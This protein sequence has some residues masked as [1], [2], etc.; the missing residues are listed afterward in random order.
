VTVSAF[1]VAG[2]RL[3]T[4]CQPRSRGYRDYLIIHHAAST[5]LLGTLDLMQ[6]G[7]RTVSSSW[8]L[9]T[10]GRFW[11]VV[12]ETMRP[13]TSASWLDD[14]A[15]TVETI[16]TSGDPNW[17]IAEDQRIALAYLAVRLYREGHLKSLTRTHI[18]GHYEVIRIAGDGY[19]TACPGPSMYL[20]HIAELARAIHAGLP[21]TGAFTPT[22]GRKHMYSIVPDAKSTTLFVVSQVTGDRKGIASVYHRDLL[23]RAR[24]NNGTDK[25]LPAELDV[26]NG[27]VSAINPLVETPDRDKII[28]ALDGISI[29]PEAMRDAIIAAA[30]EGLIS[31]DTDLG[32]DDLDRVAERVAKLLGIRIAGG[33]L[34]AS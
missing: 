31:I 12:P 22:L 24:D 8:V 2:E 6:P 7:G 15:T 4:D 29:T 17:G 33:D 32:E 26:V 18:I 23:V 28:A 21:P 5:S 30:G 3:T 13:W 1:V 14:I 27:Y 20:D 16:N 11:R 9:G 25:M 10:D 19:A 34:A